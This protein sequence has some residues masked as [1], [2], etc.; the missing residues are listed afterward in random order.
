MTTGDPTGVIVTSP[1]GERHTLSRG[2]GVRE[3]SG[4]LLVV[5]DDWVEP[6]ALYR[7]GQWLHAEVV[8]D[9]GPV[10]AAAARRTRTKREP[11]TNG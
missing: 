6:V 2:R 3:N 11:A 8:Y 5:G 4:T 10:R 9:D 1:D 7:D